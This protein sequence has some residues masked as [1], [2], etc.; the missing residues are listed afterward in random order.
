MSAAAAF[1]AVTPLGG[2]GARGTGPGRRPVRRTALAFVCAPAAPAASVALVAAVLAVPQGGVGNA[3]AAL[4]G[5]GAALAFGG[6]LSALL[7]AVPIYC[8]ALRRR[9]A[10]PPGL[11][12][13][14]GGAAAAAPW[15]ALG[16][17][18]GEDELMIAASATFGLGCIG[19]LVFTLVRDG[20]PRARG[21]AN[22]GGGT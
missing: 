17:A 3:L 12:I 19:G 15:A 8:L 18:S 21:I 22:G 2:A 13:L 9:E 4:L 5:I 6:Y 16:V 11:S 1:P 7:I 20:W 14:L 10:I